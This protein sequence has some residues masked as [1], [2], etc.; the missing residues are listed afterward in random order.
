MKTEI[1]KMRSEEP[2]SYAA[3][4]IQR[5]MCHAKDLCRQLQV[6]SIYDTDY[7]SL[8]TELIPSLP[9]TS[10]IC[11]PFFCDH[12]SGI[13]IGEGVFINYNCTFL[14]GGQITIGDHTLIG[15]NCQLYTP[16]HPMDYLPRRRGDEIEHPITIGRDCWL[17]G[18]VIVCPGVRIGDRTVVAAGSVV[19]RD[20]P[21]DVLAAGNP[22]RVKRR[23]N[24]EQAE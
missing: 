9:A 1:E 12:G 2:F 6:K 15:P 21:P 3:P 23:L 11:P 17:G 4:E 13:T 8:I 7:R 24:T 16:Q 5:S 22:A 14:D 18:G 20:L 19:T 10:T